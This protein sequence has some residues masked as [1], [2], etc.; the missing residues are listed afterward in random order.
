MSYNANTDY[1][2]LINAEN[3]K[4]ASADKGYLATLENSRNE[5]I[6]AT[7]SSYAPTYNYTTPST[8][9]RGSNNFSPSTFKG[10]TSTTG[11]VS[12]AAQA[13]IDKMNINSLLWHT[14]PA[15]QKNYEQQNV[16]LSNQLKGLAE[17]GGDTIFG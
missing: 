9:S 7:G 16:V 5:K 11:S 4:G 15:N 3:A 14:D 10:S 12:S 13:I 1:Q 6:A 17:P 8:G 2:A